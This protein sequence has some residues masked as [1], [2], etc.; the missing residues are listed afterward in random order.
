MSDP[1]NITA[2]QAT[3]DALQNDHPERPS[4][5]HKLARQFFAR[6]KRTGSMADLD[7]AIRLQE[8]SVRSTPEEYLNRAQR[9]IDL[10][11]FWYEKYPGSDHENVQGLQDSIRASRGAIAAISD[12]YP[13]R[14]ALLN[15]LGTLLGL[16]FMGTRELSVIEENI[17]VQREAISVTPTS[18]L[19]RIF[20]LN[21]LAAPLNARF[22]VTGELADL[23]ESIQV[24]RDLVEQTEPGS[25]RL[26]ERLGNLSI[27]LSVAY[28][29]LG[30]MKDLDEAIETVQKAIDIT[31]K[32]SLEQMTQLSNYANFMGDRYLRMGNFSDLQESIRAQ[33][34]VCDRVQEDEEYF[35]RNVCLSNLGIQLSRRYRRIGTVAD[36]KK[37]IQV[38]RRACDLTPEGNLNQA[39]HYSNL[40]IIL[41]HDYARTDDLEDLEEAIR[42]QREAVRTAPKNHPDL[43]PLLHN[44]GGL[45]ATRYKITSAMDDL[46]ESLQ[47]G[48]QVINL[49]PKDHWNRASYLNTLARQLEAMFSKTGLLGLINEAIEYGKEAVD[50]TEKSHPE[51]A[52]WLVNHANSHGAKFWKT[53]E[54]TDLDTAI[55]YFESAL[56]SPSVYD[57]PRIRAGKEA[58]PFYAVKPDWEKAYKAAQTAMELVPRLISQ[59]VNNE[60]KQDVLVQVYG[61]SSDAAAVALSADKGALAALRFLEQGRGVLAAS[62]EET[63]PETID[64][65]AK[66]PKL[67]ERFIQLRQDIE[68]L[69]L[70]AAPVDAREH[71]QEMEFSTPTD[72]SVEASTKINELDELVK[73]IRREPGFED[74]LTFPSEAK[75][76][77]AALYGPIIVLNMSEFRCD[78]IIVERNQ[79]RSTPLPGLNVRD[80]RSNA[81]KYHSGNLRVL[82]W[83]WEAI[84]EPVLDALGISKTLSEDGLPR[85]WWIPTG[86]LGVFPL[87]AAGRHYKGSSDTVMDS[88]MSSYSSSIKAIIRSRGQL[89]LKTDSSSP[90]RAIL[91][92]MEHTPGHPRLPSVGKEINE[93]RSIC[94]SKGFDPVEPKPR[95]EDVVS[96]LPECKIF[97]FAGHGSTN[98]PDPSQ[99]CLLL[100]DWEESPLTVSTLFDINIQQYSPFLAYL[101]ACGTGQITHEKFL[102]EG[103]HLISAFQLA[104]FRHVIGTL[105]EVDDEISVDV[106]KIAYESISRGD[107]A[108]ESVCR[109]LHRATRELRSRWLEEKH[110]KAPNRKRKLREV[111]G[112]DDGVQVPRDI[113]PCEDEDEDVGLPQWVPYVHYGV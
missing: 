63:R 100:Q 29:R 45:L 15:Q 6:R 12:T 43:V 27:G 35:D 16:L 30:R 37:A 60:D 102:D 13:H 97:H 38:G 104:G 33:Q 42:M 51:R 110:K 23:E 14:G 103:I 90:E 89:G 101:S 59:A 3:L 53:M 24:C 31:D 88:A 87:H 32:G 2:E 9:F 26:L 54:P 65:Q 70:S 56:Y 67:A 78:A 81:E 22:E 48:R 94:Q 5:L 107:M 73:R 40:A 49:T 64:L 68:S 95:K 105:W 61:L 21:N 69:K 71:R 57:I 83:L 84:A 108:D 72:L 80:I 77:S 74:F 55:S 28:D 36:L 113:V 76:K 39:K 41:Q 109:G 25:P 11:A 44:L 92:S 34:K 99:S 17:E 52:G 112:E 79:I 66:H 75:I 58:F 18:S 46:E 19:K 86:L 4:Q 10:S 47:I 50:T 111:L 96:L 85:I 1:E 7:E 82:E 91:V 106:A 62:V 8:E 98:G 93:L 20:Y